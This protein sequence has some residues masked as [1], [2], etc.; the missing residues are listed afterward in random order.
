M[1]MRS[2]ILI[3]LLVSHLLL[4]AGAVPALRAATLEE[5]LFAVPVEELASAAVRE[6][7]ARRGAIL[8][9][10]PYMSCRKCHAVGQNGQRLGPDLTRWAELPSNAKLVESVLKP[11]STVRKGFESVTLITDEGI[12][13]VGMI[14]NEDDDR[15]VL[16]DPSQPDVQK[17]FDRDQIDEVITNR[18]SLMPAGL[19]NQLS[20]RQQFLDL[21]R[22]L[23]DIRDGGL[24]RARALEPPPHLY[25]MPPLPEYEDRID[26]AA[27]IGELG[28][29]HFKRGQA[30]YQRLCVNCHG[31]H[32]KPGS[33]PTALRFAEGRFKSGADPYSMYQTLTRGFGMMQ[34]QVWMV[35]QQKYD[36]IHYIREAYLRPNNPQ[37]YVPIDEKWLSTL[38]SGDSRGP[39]PQKLE[40]WITMDYGRSLI[41]TYE[42]GQDGTNFAYKGIAVRLDA[43]PGGVSRGHDWMIFD[44]DTLRMA[45]TTSGKEFIDWNGIHFNG[46]HGRHPR[47]MGQVQAANPNGPGWADPETGSWDDSRLIG[48]DR[49]RYGPLPKEWGHYKGLY[50]HGDQSA[51]SYTLGETEIIESPQL[52]TTIPNPIYARQMVIEPNE[53]TLNLLVATMDD[54]SFTLPTDATSPESTIILGPSHAEETNPPLAKSVVLDGTFYAEVPEGDAFNLTSQD[55]TIVARI[56]TE[57]GGTLFAKTAA[58]D[59]WV[60]DGKA[61]FVRRGRLCFDIGWVGVVEGETKINDGQWHDVALSWEHESGVVK[62]YIDGQLDGRGRLRPRK[63]R[64]GDVVRIGYG[65]PDFPEPESGFQGQIEQLSFFNKALNAQQIAESSATHKPVARWDISSGDK[66]PNMAGDRLHAT[67]QRVGHRKA[68][69]QYFV[70]GVLGDDDELAWMIED[71]RAVRLNLPP[72]DRPRS[73]SVWFSSTDTHRTAQSVSRTMA[74]YPSP[75]PGEI[76]T[77]TL[78]GPSRYPEIIRTEAKLGDDQGPFAIDVLTRPAVNPWSARVRLTGFDFFPD[79]NSAAIAAWD[80]DVW[81]VTGINRPE[82]GLQWR[83][84]A[85]GLFQPLGVRI[86]DGNIFVGCRD[87]IVIL[88]DLNGDEETDY[89]ENFNNDHQVTEHFHE[90]AM[91]LQTDD[92]GNFYYAKSARHALPAVVPHHG[93]LL[94]VSRDGSRTDILAT[95]FRAANGVCLNPDGT[96]VVTDQEGHWTPKNRINWVREGGFYGNM[97]GY[98]NVEETADHAMKQPLC[99]I[100]NSFDRSPAELLWVPTN[101]WGPLGGSLLNLSYGYGKFFVVPHEEI[102]GQKQGGMCELPMPQF[103]TGLVRGRFHPTNGHLYACGMFAWAGNQQQPGGFYRIRTT[104]KPMHLPISIHANTSGVELVFTDALDRKV[105][106]APENYVITAWDLRRT[107]KYG[108][109]HHRERNWEVEKAEL[110]AD[111]KTVQLSIPNIEPTAGMEIRCFL[112]TETGQRFDRRI[113]NTIHHLR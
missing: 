10:Q 84:I 94:R 112:K 64:S 15:I 106:E 28:I 6:G 22:Y 39:S 23:I 98:H 9:Y 69:A 71:D 27:M 95:G 11:S 33:L 31:S 68:S 86:V 77:L 107:A 74:A 96:F 48:R 35:P 110:S 80:G 101:V 26:H 66:F 108:S 97:Y 111:G 18:N 92:A 53:Q 82:D 38:P 79:G 78:G 41:N 21:I 14:I 40:P 24:Q 55:Y 49:R 62:L 12:S 47:L 105:A 56:T 42:I 83:R 50:T 25:A 60:P 70:A 57:Q 65:A 5:E 100:T 85:S 30:I 7:D 3:P 99:W 8:F 109:E 19:V 1:I 93:T 67:T 2:L 63:K 4:L 44:H 87:Q 43:G 72:S 75:Q 34:P 61:L 73:M 91:G 76:Q 29:E 81:K 20:G 17:T 113:H 89:Y 59:E 46:V 16:S 102:H 32:D 103:P 51:I 88:H 37:Q 90:F 13:V 52:L 54:A 36:V 104:G 45:A 58:G